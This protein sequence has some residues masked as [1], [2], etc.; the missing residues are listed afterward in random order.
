MFY[1][2]VDIAGPV[3]PAGRL[4]SLSS[5]TSSRMSRSLAR[6]RVI[7]LCSPRD[8]Y[9]WIYSDFVADI[10]SSEF[11]FLCKVKR[12]K[13]WDCVSRGGFSEH[14]M[15]QFKSPLFLDVKLF[16]IPLTIELLKWK[17]RDTSLLLKLG[18]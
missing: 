3:L 13:M 10:I 7:S 2:Y 16:V 1:N 14:S 8:P 4:P 9:K 12:S 15:G 18:L 5:S 11:S 6:I 17:R